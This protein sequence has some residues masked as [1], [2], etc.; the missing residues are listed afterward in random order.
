MISSPTRTLLLAISLWLSAVPAR[1]EK[2][3][4][5]SVISQALTQ[6]PQIAAARARRAQS[7]AEKVQADSARWP[8]LSITVGVGPS[9]RASLV[10]GT[11][12]ESTRGRYDLAAK[13]LS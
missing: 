1:A 9:L 11:A 12:V 8:E 6:N 5:A 13:D 2:L 4:R 7:E 10:P 3:S